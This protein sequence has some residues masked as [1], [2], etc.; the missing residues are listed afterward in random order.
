VRACAHRVVDDGEAALAGVLAAEL[1]YEGA[2]NDPRI[3]GDFAVRAFDDL[4]SAW[5]CGSIHP[6]EHAAPAHAQT[7]I[8]AAREVAAQARE[9]LR[10]SLRED[11]VARIDVETTVLG[12]ANTRKL[13]DHVSRALG[14]ET[15]IRVTY[16]WGAASLG[17]LAHEA[18]RL[19]LR[20][21]ARELALPLATRITVTLK[22][23]ERLRSERA[24][25]RGG[26]DAK[27]EEARTIAREKLQILDR[28]RLAEMVLAPS[29]S[30]RVSD[31]LAAL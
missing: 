17:Q 22:N 29:R 9:I 25:P 2:P 4:G 14:F 28:R 6:K 27:I 11:D 31:V 18:A 7:A 13:S 8:D 20:R 10:R 23:G 15:Q 12:A 24:T 21:S 1:A 30:L 5:V 19:F 26:P 3:P 16:A